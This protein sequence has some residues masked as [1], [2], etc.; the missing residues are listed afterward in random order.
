MS[1][2]YQLTARALDSDMSVESTVSGNM[3][4]EHGSTKSTVIP[5]SSWTDLSSKISAQKPGSD[6]TYQLAVGFSMGK[7]FK[8]ISIPAGVTVTIVGTS[9][10]SGGAF[11]LDASSEGR[12]FVVSGLLTLQSITLQDGN[13]GGSEQFGGAIINH[14]VL[15]AISCAFIRNKAAGNNGQVVQSMLRASALSSA[16]SSLTTKP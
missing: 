13:A 15:I 16:A 14:G 2:G 10:S 12:F 3:G 11:V 6:A 8:A 9:R 1:S 4:L 5:S 7:V